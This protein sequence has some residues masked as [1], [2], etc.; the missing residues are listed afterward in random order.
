MYFIIFCKFIGFFCSLWFL[1]LRN[2]RRICSNSWWG[3][4]WRTIQR[5][6]LV[7]MVMLAC[8]SHL[9]IPRWDFWTVHGAV[10]LSRINSGPGSWGG[11][12]EDFIWLNSSEF[13]NLASDMQWFTVESLPVMPS[14]S[15][16]SHF[17][18]LRLLQ[19]IKINYTNTTFLYCWV[20][21]N[22]IFRNHAFSAS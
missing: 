10:E 4:K 11:S 16:S 8:M 19:L 9:C 7:C 18:R 1:L 20:P 5:G 17:M 2:I 22:L 14:D 21:G 3:K 15:M 12:G 6:I 13:K